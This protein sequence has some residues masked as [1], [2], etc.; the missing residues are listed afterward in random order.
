MKK[1]K[2]ISLLLILAMIMSSLVLPM[3]SSAATGTLLT[4]NFDSYAD[5]D[6][7]KAKWGVD[8]NNST[9]ITPG[10]IEKGTGADGST[11]L[12]LNRTTGTDWIMKHFAVGI[13]NT[14]II[15]ASFK[16]KHDYKEIDG[17]PQY[18]STFIALA[19][20]NNNGKHLP[21]VYIQDGV[22]YT[23]ANNRYTTKIC[24]I[25]NGK[26]YDISFDYDIVTKEIN[27]S[28]S[29]DGTECG[30]GT[31]T[32]TNGV[33]EMTNAETIRVQLWG[34]ENNGSVTIDDVNILQ[35]KPCISDNFDSYA[36]V[37]A[38]K[39]KWGVDKNN[40]T[41]ITP[42]SIEKGTGADGST[43]LQ[44]N[45]T[46][47]TDW[48]MKHFAV[49][50]YNTGIIRA[51]FK[52]KHDYKE[53]DGV[54][55][56]FSTF[57]AL[58]NKNNNGK[59]LPAVYIQDGV[60]Y[61]GANNRYTTKICDIEN[62][63]W[64]DISFDYDIV[65]KEI[66]ISASA[67]GTECGN[68]TLTVTNGVTEMT[69][70]ETMRI[71]LWG[72]ENNGSV[73]FDDIV[74]DE[75]VPA[76]DDDEGEEPEEEHLFA[77]DFN[78]FANDSALQNSWKPVNASSGNVTL[79]TGEDNSKAATLAHT[80]EAEN[81]NGIIN[82][83]ITE[84]AV[85]ANFKFKNDYT[86]YN[87]LSEYQ[88]TIISLAQHTSS[89]N[90]YTTLI[91][92]KNG[93]IYTGTTNDK[94]CPLVDE[95]G[96]QA[97][98][99]Q[100]KWYDAEVIYDI[101]GKKFTISVTD[102]NGVVYTG[103]YA[104]HPSLEYINR[105]RLQSW[106]GTVG[107]GSM[108][109]DDIVI[110]TYVMPEIPDDGEDE[111]EEEDKAILLEDNYNDYQ[112][113]EALTK[114]W[115]PIADTLNAGSVSLGKGEDE[116]N[117][118]T[119][120]RSASNDQVNAMFKE[121]VTAGEFNASFKMMN[122]YTDAEGGTTAQQTSV[123]SFVNAGSTNQYIPVIYI[124]NGKIYTGINNNYDSSR[125]LCDSVSGKWYQV[126][127]EF[128]VTGMTYDVSVIDGATVYKKEN[129]KVKSFNPAASMADVNRLRVQMWGGAS[130][131]VHGKMTMDDVQVRYTTDTVDVK[132]SDLS[133]ENTKGEKGYYSATVSASTSKINVDFGTV[134]NK[135]SLKD[136]TVILKNE[137]DGETI[138]YQGE[139]TG[140]V[141]TIPL[142]KLL[143][144]SK[145][146]SLTI[147]TDVANVANEK[148]LEEKVFNFATDA[149]ECEVSFN[150]FT[151][152]ENTAPAVSDVLAAEK[153]NVKLNVLNSTGVD[154]DVL[155]IVAYFNDD[156]LKEVVY[157]PFAMKYADY[158][159]GVFEQE[160][161]LKS[162]VTADEIH[163]FAWDTI[164]S[165]VPYTDGLEI[166]SLAK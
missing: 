60:L 139:L 95:N 123:I 116:T 75:Y 152:G 22:L 77:E 151:I 18:F 166:A 165:M 134:M 16:M 1:T 39:A 146:Y 136:S 25:E 153:A 66:N 50:I 82:P 81:I 79:G 6:A 162:N 73:T 11:A 14:G 137:T 51:S 149:G 91:Y 105:F 30:S 7:I 88:S 5:V 117:A 145:N 122:D 67:D 58:A 157:E 12:Q 108:T 144:P 84:Q 3:S 52:M 124:Q 29:A 99:E 147:T 163:V 24:D 61:T 109:V 69:N 23:G 158:S 90:Y 40:S 160:I 140:N 148:A 35:V 63:K 133:F 43:A 44:L 32:V 38:I 141:Y 13:Y 41:T 65:T 106:D 161:E 37:D 121:T 54:P 143:K 101:V 85:K 126:E 27:I 103:A 125:Y 20:K 70:A 28:A 118:F 97:I 36:D 92:I 74:V 154:K 10:S 111:E 78:E 96:N 71:Q 89:V 102:E 80:G 135:D 132:A 100:G 72:G 127:V 8:K 138:V 110:D 131:G 59:H 47:G 33:T 119:M 53:I 129:V 26:W 76:A 150:S 15:R 114:K 93:K 55:Q 2:K 112:D 120:T 45:R 34:G 142:P 9:T 17:V 21:A 128:D 130:D 62:G 94:A 156:E 42:G 57:I 49:G 48:I 46:T 98:S 159:N 107:K 104:G 19:N 31:L 68:G 64:Y 155:I 115:V 164:S 113:V 4:D 83:N 87:E 56:Y 86:G